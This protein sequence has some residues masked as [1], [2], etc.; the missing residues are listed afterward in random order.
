MM[1]KL[2]LITS[3]KLPEDAYFVLSMISKLKEVSLIVP[4]II[5]TSPVPYYYKGIYHIG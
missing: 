1:N 3:R 4:F 2:W 5:I